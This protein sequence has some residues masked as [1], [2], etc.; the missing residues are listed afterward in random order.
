MPFDESFWQEHLC[1]ATARA[2]DAPLPLSALTARATRACGGRVHVA[3]SAPAV[4]SGGASETEAFWRK[5]YFIPN[6]GTFT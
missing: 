4:H 6:I 1:T 5:W 3:N 2:L